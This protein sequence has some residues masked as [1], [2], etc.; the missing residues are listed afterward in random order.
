M[1]RPRLPSFP[2]PP[3]LPQGPFPCCLWVFCEGNLAFK[4]KPTPA[5]CG[6][7]GSTH[8]TRA[9]TAPLHVGLSA[10]L[11]SPPSLSNS[12][13]R[14][15]GFGR[16]RCAGP[17]ACSECGC[18]GAMRGSF[19]PP[20]AAWPAGAEVGDAG[21]QFSPTGLVCC[22]CYVRFGLCHSRCWVKR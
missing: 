8:R 12:V 14:A 21:S 6:V 9:T 13:G 5:P 15:A 2:L 16:P 1:R 10:S 11:L 4:V 22:Y 17:A 7:K 3:R 19:S 20:A 18:R